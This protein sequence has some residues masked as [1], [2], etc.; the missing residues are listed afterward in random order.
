[1]PQD[2]S[3]APAAAL[4]SDPIAA[5][6]RHDKDVGST[7]AQVA[8]LTGRIR[9]LTAHVGIHRKDFHTRRGLIGLVNRRRKL[10]KYLRRAKPVEYASLVAKLKIRAR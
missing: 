8:L 10:L 7:P 4:D 9:H 3:P 2:S 5:V 1:M 6:R